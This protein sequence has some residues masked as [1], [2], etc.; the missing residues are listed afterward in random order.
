MA[1]NKYKFKVKLGVER[2]VKMFLNSIEVKT[3]DF[4]HVDYMYN[5]CV[6]CLR[7]LWNLS[8][9]V[10]VAVIEKF[11]L[12]PQLGDFCG[13]ETLLYCKLNDYLYVLTIIN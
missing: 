11:R 5:V 12:I 3:L 7:N 6:A 4:A 2:C 8:K 10:G 9:K 13:N 1:I